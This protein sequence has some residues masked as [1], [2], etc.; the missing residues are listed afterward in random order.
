MEK[1]IKCENFV[2]NLVKGDWIQ[3]TRFPPQN[4]SKNFF[5][6]IDS[7]NSRE[8]LD[9]NF[10]YNDD[11][12]QYIIF[13]GKNKLHP[14]CNSEDKI[15]YQTQYDNITGIVTFMKKDTNTKKTKTGTLIDDKKFPISHISISPKKCIFGSGKKTNSK[16]KKK[17]RKSSIKPK[18][19]SCP[20]SVR[21]KRRK[22]GFRYSLRKFIKKHRVHIAYGCPELQRNIKALKDY[23]DC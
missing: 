5:C 23:Y 1:N 20:R 18:P 2:K 10:P 6:L 3:R 13:N 4:N 11:E 22:R 21:I 15:E 16:K 8:T 19:K 9:D 7:V 17:K 12:P 14:R